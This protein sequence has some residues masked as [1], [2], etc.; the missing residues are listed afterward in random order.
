MAH[1]IQKIR[2]L[3][4]NAKTEKAIEL[5]LA[6]K[7]EHSDSVLTLKN[8]LKTLKSKE[9]VGIISG[10]EV[11]RER[12]AINY[13]LLSVVSILEAETSNDTPDSPMPIKAADTEGLE[14]VIGRNGLQ[15]ISWLRRGAEKARSVCKVHMSDG[16]VGTGFLIAGGYLLTNNHNIPSNAAAQFARIELGFDGEN[17]PSVFYDLDYKDF[18]TSKGLDYSRIKI[19]DNPQVALAQ[20]GF[21]NINP[22]PPQPNGALIIIQHP[23]GRAQQIAFSEGCNVWEHRLQYTVSTEP[24]SSG[25]PVFDMNWNV[26]AIHHAGGNI[27]VNSAGNKDF[28]NQGIL[29]DYILKDIEKRVANSTKTHQEITTN[30]DVKIE[31]L[32]K[33]LLVYHSEDA[34]CAEEITSHLYNHVRQGNIELFDLQSDIS[35][36]ENK[37]AATQKALDEALLVLVL[38]SRSLYKKETREIAVAVEEC[39]GQKTV[40]PIRVSPFDLNGTAFE[41]LQGLPIGGKPISEYDNADTALY[42]TVQSIGVVIAKIL[43]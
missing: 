9:L 12:N 36:E 31:K 1:D 23:G 43:N 16:Y 28:R 41:K 25:S 27:P 3:I 18:M 40:I 30:A 29:I 11:T 37:A 6:T 35:G 22:I 14:K 34:K 7:T 10:S 39:I 8:R 13:S 26:V 2:D 4:G 20:W 17:M 5:L 33:T 24:G 19:K 21:L 42:E 15:S 38:I 32:V